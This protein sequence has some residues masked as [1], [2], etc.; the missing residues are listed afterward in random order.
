VIDPVSH[1]SRRVSAPVLERLRSE[2]NT[3]H[4][5]RVEE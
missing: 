2:L 5:Q 3:S 1:D 4:I